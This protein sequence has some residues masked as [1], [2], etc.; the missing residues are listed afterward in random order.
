M[1]WV[2]FDYG[3]VICQPQPEAD[4]ARLAQAAGCPVPEL[5]DG[6]WAH[7]L[8]YDR[9]EL[10]GVTYWQKVG[11]SAGRSFSPAEMA[12]LT[13]LDIASWLHLREGTVT[14]IEDLAAAGC[15]LALLSN[16][17]AEIAEVVAALPVAD[18]FEH[19]AFSCFL[20]SAKPEPECYQ[21]A[22]AMLGASPAEVIFLDD[23]PENVAGAAAL[24]IRGVHF[25][26]PAAARAA[27]ARYGVTAAA[28][29]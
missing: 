24:G 5:Q 20:R 8:D 28:G 27:L 19:C 9:A 25:T 13:K 12:E 7:R 17:P 22:L 29:S 16:N 23:K 1:T 21:A 14:L 15:R 3:G 2:L 6:Y 4:V 10:D 26:D 18:L 11:A